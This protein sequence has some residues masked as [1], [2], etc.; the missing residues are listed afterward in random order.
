MSVVHFYYKLHLFDVDLYTHKNMNSLQ[1]FRMASF[2]WLF[3]SLLLSL[4]W[5]WFQFS[6]AK[7]VLYWKNASTVTVLSVLIVFSQC[8]LTALG[9]SVFSWSTSYIWITI[10]F[11][12]LPHITIC[13]NHCSR[14]V[15]QN[16]GH[17]LG[18]ITAWPEYWSSVYV[19]LQYTLKDSPCSCAMN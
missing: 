18:C 12:P 11:H 17:L 15:F 13:D 7:C 4:S 2:G 8:L 1:L 6:S 19:A 14:S 3:L 9:F 16:Y 5:E 10:L